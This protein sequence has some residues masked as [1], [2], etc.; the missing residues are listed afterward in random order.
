VTDPAAWS[1][2]GALLGAIVG[3]FLAT[4]VL[5]WPQGRGLGGRSSCD[6]CQ[7]ALR[8]FEL[9]PVLSFAVQRGR[10]RRCGDRIA[11]QHP[12][13]ELLCALVGA[14][15]LW[16][17]PGIE[18]AMGAL[19]GWLL[20][21][22]GALDLR[23]F[24]LPDRL[25][26]AVALLGVA[27]CF[28]SLGPPALD[29]AIGGV[30]GFALLWVIGAG[31]KQVRGREGL[32]AGD[33][34]LFGAIGLWIGWQALPLVLLGASAAGLGMALMLMLRQRVTATTRLPLGTLMAAAAFPV[35][36]YAV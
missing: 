30:A 12:A 4:L 11:A 19:F 20:V 15:A 34:K 36:L 2:G 6:G 8:W 27:G 9:V 16:R 13:I 24:W 25:T 33:P 22:L 23:H 10:C 7:A 29:R 14:L 18:G 31:Y 17:T 32:G 1:A 21:A 26:A 35:W 5:R 28:A 3:S